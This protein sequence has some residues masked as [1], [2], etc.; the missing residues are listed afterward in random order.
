MGSYRHRGWL[1][2]CVTRQRK[3]LVRVF[4]AHSEELTLTRVFD[5]DSDPRELVSLGPDFGAADPLIAE[6]SGTHGQGYPS[7]FDTVDEETLE[8]LR[9]LGYLQ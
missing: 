9:T 4:D 5:L 8:R 6:L 3:K 1:S 2:D 7:K